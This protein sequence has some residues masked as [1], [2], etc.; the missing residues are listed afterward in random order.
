[1]F[2]QGLASDFLDQTPEARAMRIVE[3]DVLSKAEE[4][5]MAS[6]AVKQEEDDKI[7]SFIDESIASLP[8]VAQVDDIE[9]KSVETKKK[10]SKKTKDK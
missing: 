1:L 4:V 7:E 3:K 5:L 6:E 10:S 2:L 9:E 8:E